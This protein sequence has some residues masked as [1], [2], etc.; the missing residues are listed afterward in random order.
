MLSIFFYN[1]LKKL[2]LLTY[3]LTPGLLYCFYKV[4]KGSVRL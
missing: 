1:N 2:S 3:L 4:K